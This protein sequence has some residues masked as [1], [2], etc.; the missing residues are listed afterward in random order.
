MKFTYLTLFPELIEHY[1]GDALLDRAAKKNILSFEVRDLRAYATTRY[2]S[3]DDRPYGG[4]DGVVFEPETMARAL[5]D[6]EGDPYVV[7]LSPQ[8]ERLNQ[9][10]VEKLSQKKHLALICGRYG[11]IDQRF[12]RTAVQAEV[13]IGDYILS[14]GELASLVLTEAV[15]RLV[16]GVL[17][18]EHS[19]EEDS[20]SASYQGLLEAP[21]FTR[22]PIWRDLPV[23]AVLLSGDHQKINQWKRRISRLVTWK[24]RPDLLPADTS[25]QELQRE[26]A[27]ISVEERYVLGLEESP[28]DK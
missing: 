19:K 1:L 2:K 20:F 23:P 4:G 8:G 26:L 3:I 25:V 17:G 14:G 16:P 12:L 18:H 5:V 24:K 7:F 22:P 21:Q 15:S 28:H 9:R 6:I 27:E 10:L 13:S 11:G